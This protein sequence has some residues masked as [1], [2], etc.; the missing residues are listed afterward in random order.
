MKSGKKLMMYRCL[1]QTILVILMV[2]ISKLVVIPMNITP[3]GMM[4]VDTNKIQRAIDDTCKNGLGGIKNFWWVYAY[5]KPVGIRLEIHCVSHEYP[6]GSV[7][8]AG[9]RK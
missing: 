7:G 1:T 8:S 4:S 6:D 2:T 3:F 5:S 9:M